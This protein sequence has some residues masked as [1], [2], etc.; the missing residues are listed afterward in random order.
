MSIT[1]THQNKISCIMLFINHLLPT[2]FNSLNHVCMTVDI[3][4]KCCMLLDFNLICKINWPY[5]TVHIP[6]IPVYLSSLVVDQYKKNLKSRSKHEILYCNMKYYIVLQLL[7]H[8]SNVQSSESFQLKSPIPF[9]RNLNTLS[10]AIA[11]QT[12]NYFK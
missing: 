2:C 5:N 9:H 12:C 10:Q 3:C 4:F 8:F 1:E 11:I 6:P 7:F